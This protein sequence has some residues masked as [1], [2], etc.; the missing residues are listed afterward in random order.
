MI[1]PG[2]NNL[3]GQKIKYFIG[4]NVIGCYQISDRN[5]N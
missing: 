3:Q 1:N 2:T 5:E 4:Q